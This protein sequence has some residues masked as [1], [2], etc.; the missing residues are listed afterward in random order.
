M[1][2]KAGLDWTLEEKKGHEWE[3]WGRSEQVGLSDSQQC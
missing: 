2:T 1:C 3:N